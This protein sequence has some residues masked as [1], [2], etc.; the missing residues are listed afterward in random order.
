MRNYRIRWS[1]EDGR[2]HESAVSYSERVADREA[3]AKRER[4]L[5]GVEVF[6]ADPMT[7]EEMVRA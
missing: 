7:G 6:E 1:G 3:A 2:P 5:T 4:G